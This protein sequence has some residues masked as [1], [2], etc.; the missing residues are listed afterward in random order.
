[1]NKFKLSNVNIIPVLVKFRFTCLIKLINHA[2]LYIFTNLIFLWNRRLQRTNTIIK[3]ETIFECCC[4]F[5]APDINQQTIKWIFTSNIHHTY[6]LQDKF[7]S[8]AVINCWRS[9]FI[10]NKDIS[11]WKIMSRKFIS[12]FNSW[13]ILHINCYD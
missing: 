2:F 12:S 5:P 13:S 8:R 6:M 4:S 11:K 7:G 1:M 3:G 10:V 9:F